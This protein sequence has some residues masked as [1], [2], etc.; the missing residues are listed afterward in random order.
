MCSG[1]RCTY[2]AEQPLELTGYRDLHGI[3][4]NL[5]SREHHRYWLRNT[6]T[7]SGQNMQMYERRV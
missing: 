2:T 1:Y 5:S 7:A 6:Y 4:V 3:N